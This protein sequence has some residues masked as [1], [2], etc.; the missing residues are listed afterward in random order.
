MNRLGSQPGLA[1]RLE[2]GTAAVGNRLFVGRR[3]IWIT[4]ALIALLAWPL[5]I[6]VPSANLDA[7]WM[8]G[9]YMAVHDGQDF[10]TEIVF[11]Y[12]PL[13]FLS[14]PVLWFSWLAVL[15][16]VFCAAIYF[17]FVVTLISLLERM[18]GLL[19]AA[20]I[21]FL[22]LA[23][24]PDMEQL[25]L[26]LGVAWALMALREERP[27]Y[28][29]T[30]LAVGGGSLA[31]LECLIK[32]SVGPL[33][34]IVCL[35]GMIGARPNRLQWGLFAGLAAGGGLVLWLVTGQPL[36]GLWD[37]A[38]NGLQVVSGY[39]EAMLL[40]GAPAWAQFFSALLAIGLVVTAW[41]SPMRDSRAR[42]A[43]VLLTAVAAFSS[44]KYGIVRFEPIH[45]SLGLSAML[46]I[47]LVMPWRRGLAPAYLATSLV[48]GL[49]LLHL[50]PTQ[51]RLDPVK[52]V[53]SF[54][55]QAELVA[56]PGLRQG[57]VDIARASLQ[58][59]YGLDPETLDLLKGKRVAIDP[60][61]IAVA[62]AYELDWQ[63]LPVI[64]NYT[65]Y[66]QDLDRLNSE[67]VEDAENG[68]QM[69][70]RQNPGGTMPLG[71]ARSFQNRLPAWDPPEQNFKIVCNFIPVHQIPA[72]QVLERVPDRCGPEKLISETEANPGEAVDV[73]QAGRGQLVL[74]KIEG[75]KIEGLEKLRSLL[76][77]PKLRTA[78]LNDGLVTYGVVADTTEDG[79][80]VSRDPALD[81]EEGFEQLPEL[82]N[83]KIEGISN[84]LHFQFYRV[85]V[86]VEKQPG[87]G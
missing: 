6:G 48:I 39:N 81:S 7:S 73:P 16:Y 68:P 82:K 51:P 76:F 12:G 32:L 80:V 18:T 83:L 49:V 74:M 31:A 37:Y 77:R 57:D 75:A 86:K 66:T 4:A 27:D 87:R 71:G 3:R 69:I 60:W 62:W 8:S 34:L 46:G 9:L 17:A 65:A 25:P 35:L 14:W 58:A 59:T 41:F 64:Q 2:A 52:N 28:A 43:A 40:G 5:A 67:A 42:W 19:G 79:M 36:G 55:E 50:Y 84:R 1:S 10:G 33:I 47:W 63:P 85:P 45:L 56:R 26:I 21:A 11:T 29:V 44:Y 15:S 72:W 78:T 38:V 54:G 30:L 13:G 20:V 70:L 22:Y 24:V 61:E 23:T 53:I